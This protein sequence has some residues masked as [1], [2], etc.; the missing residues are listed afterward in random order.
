ME[1][2]DELDPGGC[3]EDYDLRPWRRYLYGSLLPM[4]GR[5]AV[6]GVYFTESSVNFGSRGELKRGG[7]I[8]G[9]VV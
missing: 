3:G 1:D 4:G 5:T 6:L 8:A 2:V 7:E 9:W